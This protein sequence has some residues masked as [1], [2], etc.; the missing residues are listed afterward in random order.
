MMAPPLH[1]L[2]NKTGAPEICIVSIWLP[3]EKRGHEEWLTVPPQLK[4]T[5]LKR[6]AS[7]EHLLETVDRQNRSLEMHFRKRAGSMKYY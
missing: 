3:F 2:W 6:T 4:S 5:G 7:Q 1:T